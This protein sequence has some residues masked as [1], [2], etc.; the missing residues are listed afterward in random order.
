M[1]SVIFASH[2]AGDLLIPL[3]CQN[4]KHGLAR[5]GACMESMV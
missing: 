5:L 4:M 2:S 3:S 1:G